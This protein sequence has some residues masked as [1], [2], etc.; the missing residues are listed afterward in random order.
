MGSGKSS[1]GSELASK[2]N[3]KLV[4]LDDYIQKKE[5]SSISKIF[6][7][8]GEIYFR[9]IERA[10]LEQILLENNDIILSTGGGTPCYGDTMQ[11]LIENKSLKTVY[12]Q[13]SL[14]LLTDR[15]QKEKDK[16]PVIAHLKTK[17]DL[18]DFIRKHLFE[19]SYYYNQSSEKINTDTL[20]ITE[21]TDSII[22]KLL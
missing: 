10:Y 20:S 15:L 4:D 21:I 7:E 2:L 9:K 6:S 1:V 17:E 18:N 8:K 5:S 14:D 22:E 13:T 19:R 3:R 12:L 16:R 11:F